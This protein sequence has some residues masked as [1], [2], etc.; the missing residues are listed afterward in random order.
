MTTQI[1]IALGLT[2]PK[3]FNITA[4][5]ENYQR[6]RAADPCNALVKAP[7]GAPNGTV[8]LE[9]CVV[10]ASPSWTAYGGEVAFDNITTWVVPLFILIINV[11]YSSFRQFEVYNQVS[12]A[13]HLLG[14]PIDAT[15]SLLT[16][17]D[18][19]RRIRYR[20]TQ[21]FGPDDGWIY[22]TILLALDDHCFSENFED[23]MAQFRAI[24]TS[25]NAD[26]RRA[27]KIAAIRLS[28]SRVN[29]THRALFAIGGYCVAILSNYVKA[30]LEDDIEI[31]LPHTIALRQLFYW[32]VI[33]IVLSAA[34]GGFRLNG[35]QSM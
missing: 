8:S 9:N 25:H 31:C 4:G 33:S 7:A 22:A 3:T 30:I 6:I 32:L 20:C 21:T 11:N 15:W 14:N 12:I 16:K 29:N 19:G 13:L 35:Q 10:L 26:A 27:C 28:V 24:A 1:L 17:L 34:V 18:V 23:R 2:T 5:L